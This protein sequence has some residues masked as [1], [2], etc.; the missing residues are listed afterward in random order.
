[1]AETIAITPE[2][3]RRRTA[4]ALL[5]ELA[6]TDGDRVAFRSKHRN[7]HADSDKG[8]S[9]LSWIERGGHGISSG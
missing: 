8:M 5:C 3:L 2:T 9:A 1:M 4:P 7:D 6:R